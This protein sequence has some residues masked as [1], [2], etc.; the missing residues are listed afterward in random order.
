[1]EQADIYAYTHECHSKIYPPF[2]HSRFHIHIHIHI[3]VYR[4]IISTLII[5]LILLYIIWLYTICLLHFEYCAA[6]IVLT[7]GFGAHSCCV[8]QIDTTL[9]PI[10]NSCWYHHTSYSRVSVSYT[11]LLIVPTATLTLIVLYTYKISY[12]RISCCDSLTVRPLG[13][14]VYILIYKIL[15]VRSL[16]SS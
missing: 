12:H 10:R 15:C 14:T 11:L 7:S 16:Y 4:Y 6:P 9:S 3:H 5:R 8:T 2:I 1:M 13:Y